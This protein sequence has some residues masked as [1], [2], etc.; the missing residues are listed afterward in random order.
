ME[1]LTLCLDKMFSTSRRPQYQIEL[2]KELL[3][4]SE[5]LED[6]YLQTE[7]PF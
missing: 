3:F 4:E 6:D 5:A 7:L 1:H 2:L